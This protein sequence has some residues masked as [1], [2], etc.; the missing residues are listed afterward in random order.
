L[1]DARLLAAL[2]VA[3]FVESVD[4]NP[5]MKIKRVKTDLRIAPRRVKEK[6]G[7]SIKRLVSDT[8]VRNY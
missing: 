8:N 1:G 4:V 2:F 3:N 6:I 7:N 5:A